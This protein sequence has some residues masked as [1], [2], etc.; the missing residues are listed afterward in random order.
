MP[1]KNKEDRTEAVRRH[2]AK[3]KEEEEQI[4]RGEQLQKTL[5]SVLKENF[6]FHSMPYG[7]FVEIAQDDY[8]IVTRGETIRDKRTGKICD[9]IEV[10]YGLN[11]MIVIETPRWDV[12]RE[13]AIR[14]PPED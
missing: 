10:L 11:M 2:R 6:G 7:C 12:P 3:K 4:E 1:Y 14:L 13:G 9:N 5:S 8:E